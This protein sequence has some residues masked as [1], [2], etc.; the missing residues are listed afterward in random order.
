ML[1]VGKLIQQDKILGGTPRI[2][3]QNKNCRI[4]EFKGFAGYFLRFILGFT[5]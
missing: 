2:Y 3:E 4:L 1:C 5:K